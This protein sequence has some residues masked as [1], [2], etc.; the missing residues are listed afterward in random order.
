[1]PDQP[2]ADTPTGQ[3]REQWGERAALRGALQTGFDQAGA[4]ANP[5]LERIDYIR[6]VTKWIIGAIAVAISLVVGTSPL[7]N[8]GSLPLGWRLAFAVVCGVIG[9]AALGFS[10]LSAVEVLKA[11]LMDITLLAEDSELAGL[12]SSLNPVLKKRY[13]IGVD[14]IK[15]L[16]DEYFAVRHR[17]Q[18]AGLDDPNQMGA[19]IQ[20]DVTSYFLLDEAVTITEDVAAFERVCQ[21]FERFCKRLTWVVITA[22][23]ALVAFAWAA[24]PPKPDSTA[25]KQSS[26]NISQPVVVELHDRGTNCGTQAP[27]CTAPASCPALPPSS[28]SD[29]TPRGLPS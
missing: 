9:V 15:E 5:W 25:S 14:G 3:I 22:T 11:R 6:N 29:L 12:R 7:T 13:P 2:P 1:M 10:F 8:L 17:I 21:L 27:C 24:N 4:A 18:Q 28:L 20:R 16:S 26:S 23:V 19:S